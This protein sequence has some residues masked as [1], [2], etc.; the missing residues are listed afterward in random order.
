MALTL[1]RPELDVWAPGEH[2][3][4]F[5]GNNHAFT[6]AT[7][8]LR[9]WETDA[10][11]QEVAR[12]ADRVR[13]ALGDL[14]IAFP[15]MQ[16]TFRGRG[17]MQGLHCPEPG[18]AERVCAEAFTRGLILE[19]SGTTSDVVKLLPPLT[20]DDETLERGLNLLRESFAAAL[21]APK[22]DS[23]TLLTTNP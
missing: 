18:L 1:L 5:R 14:T 4:T 11:A 17:L 23:A 2:N 7:A 20:I 6:T 9:H 16:G 15:A 13:T 10:L 12:K 3:G 19:T 21:G 22:P 8:A